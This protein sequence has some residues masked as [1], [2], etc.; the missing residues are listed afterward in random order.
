M[1]FLRRRW[2]VVSIDKLGQVYDMGY[3]YWTQKGAESMAGHLTIRS[4]V[5]WTEAKARLM[6]E[7]PTYEAARV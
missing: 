4:S 3:R 7:P 6:G 1:I 5:G 2:R